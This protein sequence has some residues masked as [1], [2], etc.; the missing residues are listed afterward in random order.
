ME[1]IETHHILY[2]LSCG[3]FSSY[4]DTT[5]KSSKTRHNDDKP[6]VVHVDITHWHVPHRYIAGLQQVGP[7]LPAKATDAGCSGYPYPILGYQKVSAVVVSE[8]P[9]TGC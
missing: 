4:L 7:V 1:H 2:I 3:Y 5:T 8:G 9:S 6:V